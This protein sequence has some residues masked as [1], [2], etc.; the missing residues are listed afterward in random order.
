[1]TLVFFYLWL[2]SFIVTQV[3]SS[4][5]LFN[6]SVGAL[7]FLDAISKPMKTFIVSPKTRFQGQRNGL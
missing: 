4:T 1:M 5:R 7:V 6:W 3:F 2:E